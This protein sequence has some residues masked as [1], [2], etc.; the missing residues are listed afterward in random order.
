MVHE[1]KGNR[2]QDL[3]EILAIE[4]LAG[5]LTMR[6]QT[7]NVAT[8]GYWYHWLDNCFG[9]LAGTLLYPYTRL[10][11]LLLTSYHLLPART[12]TVASR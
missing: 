2:W 7:E 10:L 9:V 1:F 11:Y 5:S 4:Q 3:Q 12:I 6:C 8:A